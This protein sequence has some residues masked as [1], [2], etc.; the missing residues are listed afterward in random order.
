MSDIDKGMFQWTSRYA[1]LARRKENM[2]RVRA[3]NGP[4]RHVEGE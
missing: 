4:C 3:E 1:E 2:A